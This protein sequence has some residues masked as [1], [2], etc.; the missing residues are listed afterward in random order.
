MRLKRWRSKVRYYKDEID[1]KTIKTVFMA[2]L[3]TIAMFMALLPAISISQAS[4]SSVS[5]KPLHF[6]FHH[7]DT[8]V[9]FA[10]MQT[11]YVMN[12]TQ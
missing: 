1:E 5:S 11:Y 9:P 6:Y 3:A 2:L 10:G 4:P 8:S 12:T 7:I